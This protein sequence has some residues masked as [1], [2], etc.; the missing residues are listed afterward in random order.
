MS[1]F[2]RFLSPPLH[3]LSRYLY[4]LVSAR[5]PTVLCARNAE[6]QSAEWLRSYRRTPPSPFFLSSSLSL[7]ML[8]AGYGVCLHVPCDSCIMG[9]RASIKACLIYFSFT[10]RSVMNTLLVFYC[11]LAYL[12]SA[13]FIPLHTHTHTLSLSLS[14][15]FFLSLYAG[16]NLCDGI[17][18][19]HIFCPVK[20]SQ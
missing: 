15:S 9:L 8:L 6:R 7:R 2:H 20:P 10:N 4:C 1:L 3:R 19:P 5:I 12:L 13:T 16:P 17:Y 14:L 18:W 11:P